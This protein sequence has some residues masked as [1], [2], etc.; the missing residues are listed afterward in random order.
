MDIARAVKH[1]LAENLAGIG[2][3]YPQRKSEQDWVR[4]NLPRGAEFRDIL[5]AVQEEWNGCDAKR[6]A[7][8][9][10]GDS[11]RENCCGNE[12]FTG[13]TEWIT[14]WGIELRGPQEP[15]KT[16]AELQ[17]FDGTWEYK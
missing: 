11:F 14:E 3:P 15:P 17:I 2:Y 12:V 4:D 5:G 7:E 16:S 8:L 10:T 6:L 9:L 1:V 13:N